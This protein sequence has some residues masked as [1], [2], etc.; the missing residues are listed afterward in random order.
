MPVGAS[1]MFI[2]IPSVIVVIPVQRDLASPSGKPC[3][4]LEKQV[5]W[6]WLGDIV[7]RKPG[8]T[9]SAAPCAG[10]VNELC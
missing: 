8:R 7:T 6:N 5:E 4:G 9:S 2:S 3:G 10:T 1:L